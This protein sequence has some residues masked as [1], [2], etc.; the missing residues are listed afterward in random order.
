LWPTAKG[1]KSCPGSRAGAPWPDCSGTST[2]N[3][4]V[5]GTSGATPSRGS[6]SK[7]GELGTEAGPRT[8]DEAVCSYPPSQSVKASNPRT[9]SGDPALFQVSV[10]TDD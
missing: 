2:S 8:R 7:A 6:G 3:R 5:R 4:K 1:G 10:L 9:G